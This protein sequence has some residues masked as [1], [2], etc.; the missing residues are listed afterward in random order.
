ME[1]ELLYRQIGRSIETMPDLSASPPPPEVNRWL[2]KACALVEA[3]RRPL[4]VAEM[5]TNVRV[6]NSSGFPYMMATASMLQGILLRSSI[7]H[8]AI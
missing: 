1:P 8:L 5:T 7:V 2:G 3:T 6:L 4:D